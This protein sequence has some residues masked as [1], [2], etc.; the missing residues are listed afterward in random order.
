[1][2]KRLQD[3]IVRV[4]LGGVRVRKEGKPDPWLI[5]EKVKCLKHLV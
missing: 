1:M 3:D 4:S 2:T 5:E